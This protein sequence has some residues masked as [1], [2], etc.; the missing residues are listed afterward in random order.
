MLG[1]CFVYSRR[2]YINIKQCIVFSA[3]N[4]V[5]MLCIIINII[6]IENISILC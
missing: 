2:S 1:A 5:Q 3:L 6:Y 4:I